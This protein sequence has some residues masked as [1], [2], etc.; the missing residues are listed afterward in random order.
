MKQA[1][2]LTRLALMST[3]EAAKF[4]GVSTSTLENWRSRKLFGVP[5]FTADELHGGTWYYYRERV[6]QLKSVYQKGTLQ[7]MYQL[8]RK[9]SDADPRVI[10]P[11]NFQNP[12]SRDCINFHTAEKS[13]EILGVDVATLTRWRANGILPADVITHDK[14]YL[15]AVETIADFQM[16]QEKAGKP[17][18]EGDGAENAQ[19]D[20]VDYITVLLDK[21]FKVI[22]SA[23]CKGKT[24][25]H[26][27]EDK[28]LEIVTRITLELLKGDL[29]QLDKLVFSAAL[30]EYR[31]GNKYF[32]LRMLW[33]K[34]GGGNV[35]T[36]EVKKMLIESVKRLSCTLVEIDMSEANNAFNYTNK[37]KLIF[38]NYL[39]PCR[40]I[41]ARINGQTVDG[42]FQI[43]AD[44][45]LLEVA[46]LKKQFAEKAAE[47]LAVPTLRNTDSVLKLKFYLLERITAIIG[48]HEKH[49]PHIVGRNKD[50]KPKYKSAKK[51]VGRNGTAKTA[52][53]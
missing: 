6:E 47:L 33:H 18:D 41:E 16:E 12:P 7:N 22:F 21:A 27:Y 31:A 1:T 23:K 29:N 39:L 37:A 43:L 49:K 42:V 38:R 24:K 44:P 3:S 40:M 17:D 14:I 9:F 32:S 50:G 45:P 15:Y 30:S 5:F 8:A 11:D 35:L 2:T 20:P 13:A 53:P 34:M 4:L 19:L 51:L 10:F 26:I 48:S 36:D 25:R 52:S 46:K 28:Q